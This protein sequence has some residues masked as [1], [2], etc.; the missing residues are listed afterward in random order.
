MASEK[1]LFDKK[2]LTAIQPG[3]KLA[4]YA[5]TKIRGFV[6]YV[7]TKGVKTF[8]IYRKVHGR[9]ER[10]TLGHFDATLPDSREFPQGIELLKVLGSTPD[11]N[12]GMARRLANAVNY[13]LDNG[14]NVAE[15]KRKSRGELSL[16]EMMTKYAEEYSVPRKKDTKADRWSFNRYLGEVTNDPTKSARFKK[17][18]PAYSVNWSNR[19]LSSIKPDEIRRLQTSLANE[20]SGT[21]ANRVIELLR[22]LYIKASDWG[23]FTGPMPTAGIDFFPERV[24][25]RFL[26]SSELPTFWTMLAEHPDDE[27]RDFICLLILTGVRS[28]NLYSMAWKDVEIEASEWLIP[29]EESKNDD[30]MRIVLVPEAVQIL[31]DRLENADSEWVFPGEASCGHLTTVRK[32]W[33]SFRKAAGIM[34]VTMHDLRRSLGSWQARTGASLIIIGK[35]LG[36]KSL[37]ATMIYSQLDTDP[38][39]AAVELATSAMFNVGR[40]KTAPQ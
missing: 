36:H 10:I 31:K 35:T 18:K 8:S 22:R 24:R 15:T 6:L 9:P 30:S 37:E 38:V 4:S 11:L 32:R 2:N 17:T 21:T 27:F 20:V 23:D 5:D 14:L 26:Q 16:G 19:K 1:I 39:R 34:D 12:V 28:G 25:K 3:E 33:H 7:S 29:A 13:S 40:D